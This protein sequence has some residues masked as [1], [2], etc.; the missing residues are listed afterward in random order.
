MTQLTWN[1]TVAAPQLLMAEIEDTTGNLVQIHPLQLD[2]GLIEMDQQTITLGRGSECA[3]AIHEHCVSREH[4]RIE[5]RPG[6]YLIRDL[7]STNG[8]WVNEERVTSHCL[9][10][11]DRIRIGTHI[12]KFVASGDIETQYHETVYSMMTH[13]GLTGIWNKRSFLDVIERDVE[14][15]AR[16]GHPLTLALFDIDHFKSINDT[17]GHLAGDQ[18]LR[19]L[20]D[21]I[22]PLVPSGDLLA[23]YGGEEFA[24]LLANVTAA[25]SVSQAETWRMVIDNSP[26]DTDEGPIPVT[27][28]IG[29]ADLASIDTS[30]VPTAT[31]LIQAADNKLYEAKRTGRN[32]VCI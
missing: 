26:F 14:R 3:I 22:S 8:T 30:E 28:S 32:Q 20:C 31:Q 4:A 17:H 10:P 29:L 15:A 7:D 16:A 12:F 25:D 6:S 1:E 24:I 23:R 27:I 5:R 11:G 21:R 9:K 19:Q 2:R 13:D 18:V